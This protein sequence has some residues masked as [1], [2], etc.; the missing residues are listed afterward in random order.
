[1]QPGPL[2]GEDVLSLNLSAGCAHQCSFCSVRAAP[3]YPGDHVV[4]LYKEMAE[5]VAEELG[6]RRRLPRAVYISPAGDPFLPLLAA[7]QETVG[8]VEELSRRGVQAWLM[9]RGYVRPSILSRLSNFREHVRVTV[10]MTT[11][12]REL[13]HA[14]EPLA[15]P[16]RLRMRLI[17]KLINL[18]IPVQAAIEPLIPGLTDTHANLL[19]LLEALAAAGVRRVSA[20]YLYLRPGIKDNLCQALKAYGRDTT[21]L[22]AFAEGPTLKGAL[23]AARF[24]PKRR[25]QRGYAALMSLAAMFGITVRISA[26]SNPD[27][28]GGIGPLGSLQLSGAP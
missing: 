28:S 11:M 6:R 18:G 25:R 7:Q 24:L 2:G 9:T 12:E 21:C 26:V 3:S 4:Y 1:L 23:A 8:V 14:L 27:F 16:P 5:R 10:A 19:G 17:A 22:D 13:V 15:A 20:S